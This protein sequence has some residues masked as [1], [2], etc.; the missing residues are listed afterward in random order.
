[1]RL[2]LPVLLQPVCKVRYHT[3]GYQAF[4]GGLCHIWCCLTNGGCE[5]GW[6]PYMSS[7]PPPS[8][9]AKGSLP[10]PCM[11]SSCSLCA[12]RHDFRASNSCWWS[13]APYWAASCTRDLH[14]SCT[15]LDI[16][17]AHVHLTG[18]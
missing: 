6:V 11:A 18:S 14:T 8:I 10:A 15:A 3:C 1:M 17:E 7:P 13:L 5:S 4:L 12:G 16:P 9:S 2:H